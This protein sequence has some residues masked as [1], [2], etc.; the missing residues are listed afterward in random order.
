MVTKS[1]QR[2]GRDYYY[3]GK[4]H[5]ADFKKTPIRMMFNWIVFIALVI[6]HLTKPSTDD[7]KGGVVTNYVTSSCKYSQTSVCV[8]LCV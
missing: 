8:K 4:D 6:A 7:F 3:V 5:I 2:T 1:T